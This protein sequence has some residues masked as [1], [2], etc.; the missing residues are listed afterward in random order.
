MLEEIEMAIMCGDYEYNGGTIEVLAGD[1][2][3]NVDNEGTLLM[4]TIAGD[5]VEDFIYNEYAG[6][7]ESIIMGAL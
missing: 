2:V 6:K 7:V 1:Y 4:R 5:E 3:F